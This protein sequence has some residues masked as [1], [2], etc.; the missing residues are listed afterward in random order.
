MVQRNVLGGGQLR[1]EAGL[2]PPGG[3]GAAV[4]GHMVL[5]FA[6]APSYGPL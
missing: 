4:S 2:R 6:V 3:V 5:I 1:R